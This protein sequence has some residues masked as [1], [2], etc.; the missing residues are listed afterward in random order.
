MKRKLKPVETPKLLKLD[1]GC[2]KKPK[3]GF[4]GV[5]ARDFG[6]PH[7]VDLTKPWPWADNSVSE[8]TCSHFL[9]HLTAMERA[10]FVNELYRVLIPGGKCDIATPH[11]LNDRAYGDPTHQWPP[12]TSFW[13]YY[14]DKGWRETQ[15]PHTCDI[16]KCDFAISGGFTFMPDLAARNDEYRN[17]AMK[18]FANTAMDMVATFI[19]KK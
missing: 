8:A 18:H 5:D 10:H 14:L 16:F 1:L 19:A 17:F 7:K 12:V 9:E 11:W 13:F 15:A 3:E 2:G 6:Q 4:E